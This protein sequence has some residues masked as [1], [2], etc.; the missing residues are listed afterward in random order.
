VKKGDRMSNLNQLAI[1]IIGMDDG[2]FLPRCIDYASKI[3]REVIYID[4]GLDDRGQLKAKELSIK[5]V[6]PGS[7]L[8]L[9]KSEWVLFIRPDEFPV[10]SS[11][12]KLKKILRN[13]GIAGLGV[14]TRS[15]RGNKLLEDYQWIRKLEQFKN[16][17]RFSSVSKIEPRLVRTNLAEKCLEALS[18]GSPG[19]ISWICEKIA[20]GI[21]IEAI[22]DEQSDIEKSTRDHDMR[23]LKGELFYDITPEED[24]V[25]LSER[26]TG[27]RILHRGQ[28]GGYMDG[29]K[30]GFGNLKMYIPMLEFLCKEGYYS[31]ARELFETWIENRPDD[32]ELYNAKLMGGMI[33]A[34]LLDADKA[35]EW[36]KT[37]EDTQKG[38]LVFSDLGKL[39]LI[40]GE[41]DNAIEYLKRAKGVP[42][43]PFLKIRILSIIEREVW[44]P[45]K[46]SLCMVARDEEEGIGKALESVRDF[47]DEVIVVDTGSLDRT[48]EIANGFGVK[49]IEEPWEDDFSRVKNRAIREAT[50]DYIFFM[51]ADEFID[52]RDK[53]AFALFKMLLPVEKNI[54]FSLKIEPAKEAK[55]LSMSYLDRLLKRE[56]GAYQI[57]LFPRKEG[58]QFKGRVFEDLYEGLQ[59]AQTTIE[60]NDL[61]KITHNMLGRESREIRKLPAAA[62]SFDSLCNSSKAIEGALLFVRAGDLDQAYPWLIKV[63]NAVPEFYVKTAELYKKH[64]KPEMAKEILTKA[65]EEYPESL[66][67]IISLAELYYEKADYREVISLLENRGD[68]INEGLSPEDAV[69]SLYCLGIALL[70][71]GNLSKGVEKISFALQQDSSDMRNRVAAIFA[72]SKADQ[73][74]EALQGAAEI[75]DEQN[76]EIANE[77]NDFVDVGRI[78]MAMQLHFARTGK[79][80][81]ADL[82][83]R[84]VEYVLKTRV[85]GDGDIARMTAVIE[86]LKAQLDSPQGC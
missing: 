50:G 56:D 57:R 20:P 74:E 43:D 80:E 65:R 17:E 45:L 73:W 85:S 54:A 47:V 44:H 68:H 69:R 72:F 81:E 1:C 83:R 46:L 14:Y 15:S 84:I 37:I 36:F 16:T 75:A 2:K 86:E 8:S 40:K 31:E 48:R 27:F 71:T 4:L 82:C 61:F 76:I 41:K 53:F 34:N 60:K 23:C 55:S 78:F 12:D 67:I 70:E 77:V 19:T 62:R 18:T 38:S 79:I 51:D 39:Y 49:V 59:G 11:A 58:I 29:A 42:G 52:P 32:K 28:L 30:R 25:E 13:K 7:L 26:Y 21:K 22:H 9:L 66:Q 64:G 24:M 3:T 6:K 5:I 10:L 33:Y 35:I 63:R